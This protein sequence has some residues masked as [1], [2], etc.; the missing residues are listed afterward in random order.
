MSLPPSFVKAIERMA[1]ETETGAAN[2]MWRDNGTEYTLIRD[3]AAIAGI[4][5]EAARLFGLTESI[6]AC[7]T[8][9]QARN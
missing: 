3:G 1:A 9:P 6:E 8:N 4:S 2:Y 7:W 5:H